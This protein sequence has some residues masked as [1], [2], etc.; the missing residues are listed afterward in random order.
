MPGL[1]QCLVTNEN[2]QTLVLQRKGP[3][4][5]APRGREVGGAKEPPSASSRPQTTGD[6][7]PPGTAPQPTPSLSRGTAQGLERD[8][9][10]SKRAFKVSPISLANIRVTRDPEVLTN[11]P[12]VTG[13]PGPQA[14]QGTHVKSQLPSPPRHLASC[15]SRAR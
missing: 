9:Q 15:L 10:G 11:L 4:G 6:S 1:G 13:H 7:W 3:A 12:E 2:K 5:E 14:L 8:P